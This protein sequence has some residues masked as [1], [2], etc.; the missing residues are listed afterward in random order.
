MTDCKFKVGET[1]K[2]REGGEWVLVARN[3]EYEK[4]LVFRH[5]NTGGIILRSIDGRADYGR[6]GPYDI[7]PNKRKEWVITYFVDN[8]FWYDVYDDYASAEKRIHHITNHNEF[9]R[10]GWCKD[11]RGPMLWESED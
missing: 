4:P 6:E 10:Q 5:K 3:D 2:D 11:V 7:L 8:T 1:Y 9:V